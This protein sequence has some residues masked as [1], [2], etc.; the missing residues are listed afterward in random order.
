MAD[1]LWG[2]N[3]ERIPIH[4]DQEHYAS[5][6]RA[7]TWNLIYNALPDPDPILRR[8]GKSI[9]G[10]RDLFIDDQL[11]TVWVA[12][13][14]GIKSKSWKIKAG[15][16][17]SSAEAAKDY[18]REMIDAW[19]IRN[20]IENIM[21]AVAFGFSPQEI[22]WY[23]D[24]ARWSIKD[25]VGKPPEWFEFDHK[26]NL[27][28]KTNSFS[29]ERVPENRFI[30][31][32]NRA[33]YKNPYGVKLLSKVFWPITFKRNGGKWWTL[34]VEKYGAPFLYGTYGPN[35]S[36]KDKED[37]IDALYKIAA[38]SIAIGPEDTKINIMSDSNKQAASSVYE[39]YE[40]FFNAAISKVILGQTLTTEI[41]D[42][43]GSYS[44]AK[45][46]LSIKDELAADDAEMVEDVFNQMFNMI[47]LFNW[48]PNVLPPK[49]KFDEPV[50]IKKDQADRDK[51]LTES[52]VIW[53]NKHWIEDYGIP[54][55]HFSIKQEPAASFANEEKPKRKTFSLFSNETTEDYTKRQLKKG[56]KIYDQMIETII[57]RLDDSE[58]F[59][60]ARTE[61]IKTFS[62][63]AMRKQRQ[64]LAA[65]IDNIRYV[66]SQ[67]GADDA[68]V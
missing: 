66:G 26:N 49:F 39:S 24:G 43:G 55:H 31:A 37:L 50:N 2:P 14:A 53:T 7:E 11:E 16:D 56:Q 58:S 47:T 3:G 45:V 65:H 17:S 13:L 33:T 64:K 6:S 63:K 35:A 27:L 29:S 30:I 1:H 8:M 48:G 22:L 38:T 15:D 34:F 57:D 60:E 61:L 32:Q 20:K 41:G 52:G 5:L 51:T 62:S 19:S 9:S 67:T 28:F 12:R 25:L 44:A 10:L 36:K 42:T 40:K 68:K 54:E 18:C 23:K 59:D 46:H 21:E 4:K